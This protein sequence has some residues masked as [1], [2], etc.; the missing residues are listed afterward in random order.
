MERMAEHQQALL[1]AQS[2]P[3]VGMAAPS[4]PPSPSVRQ[5]RCCLDSFGHHRTACARTGVL[6][7]R[8]FAIESAA[9]RVCREGGVR[10]ATNVLLRDLD[11]A[12]PVAQGGRRLEIIADGLPLFGGVQFAVVATFV[13]LL[14]CDGTGRPSSARVDGAALAVARSR[15]ERTYPELV[16]RQA[17][18][19]LV[20]LAGEVGGRW[21]VETSTFV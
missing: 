3:M 1:R 14:H 5:C 15:K 8:R 19:W 16:G 20:V 17:R 2:G 18:A 21:S 12:V 9:S 11:L 10:V 6:G 13:S 7:R 4:S